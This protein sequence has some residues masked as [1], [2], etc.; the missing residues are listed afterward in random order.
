ME[1]VSIITGDPLSD[2]IYAYASHDGGTDF[3]VYDTS[4]S[5]WSIITA[6]WEADGHPTFY[7]RLECVANGRLYYFGK[8]TF[9]NDIVGG[10]YYTHRGVEVYDLETGIWTRLSDMPYD[11]PETGRVTCSVIGDEIFVIGGKSYKNG[12]DE[13]G[14]SVYEYDTRTDS[15]V[16]RQPLPFY[17]FYFST[18]VVGKDIYLIGGKHPT[19]GEWYLT[20][21]QEY[22]TVTGATTLRKSMPEARRNHTS[23]VVNGKIYVIGGQAPPGRGGRLDEL[24]I[25]V[26]AYDP[27]DDTWKKKSFV[28]TGRVYLGSAVIGN[29]IYVFGGNSGT[30]KDPITKV[31][32]YDPSL[33]N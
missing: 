4:S 33:D 11:L 31:E 22:N 3:Q 27:V 5:A 2:H 21:V 14:T 9:H 19:V 32:I 29:K 23:S 20:M 13:N 8:S 18:S 16:A 30:T 17:R 7:G 6:P 1:G 12:V 15:W 24:I 10:G 25:P 28:P 26:L